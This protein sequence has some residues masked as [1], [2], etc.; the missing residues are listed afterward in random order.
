LAP[1]LTLVGGTLAINT[2]TQ[3]S[4]VTFPVLKT[5]GGGFQVQNNTKLLQVSFPQVQSIAGALDFYGNFTS[6]TLPALKDNRG[7]FN[8]QSSGDISSDCTT[9][10]AETGA[11]NVIKGKFVC[12]GSQS[13]PGNI[14]STPTGTS[15]TASSTKKSEAGNLYPGTAA[16]GFAGVIA[17]VFGIM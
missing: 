13:A 17:A 7:A 3:L 1:N 10:K 16:V 12:A 5:I 15:S 8:I 11:N 9:F 4:N 14:G 2:N 6:V